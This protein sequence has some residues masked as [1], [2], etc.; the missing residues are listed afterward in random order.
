[1]DNQC[2][3]TVLFNIVLT[4]E[5]QLQFNSWCSRFD[6]FPTNL[7]KNAR[8]W[9]L[10]AVEVV[11]EADCRAAATADGSDIDLEVLADRLRKMSPHGPG[12]L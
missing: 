3:Q 7:P 11:A 9:A 8:Q 12:R 4:L 6:R 10:G 5:A 2:N 1:M